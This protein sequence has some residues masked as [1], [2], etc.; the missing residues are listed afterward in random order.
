MSKPPLPPAAVELLRRPN[1]SVM[2]TLRADGTPA[3]YPG[4]PYP[5][6][7]RAR[8]SARIEVGRWHGWGELKD[9]DQAST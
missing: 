4:R 6:R 8:V 2:A 5:D 9:S 3:H 1:P 7:A